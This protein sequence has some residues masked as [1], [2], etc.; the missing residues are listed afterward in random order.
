ISPSVWAWRHKRSNFMAK[1]LD[2]L[3]TIFPFEKPFFS[4]TTLDVRYI[5]HPLA[6]EIQN[7][8]NQDLKKEL[9][10]IFP[11][12]RKT[13]IERNFPL[14]LKAAKKLL[15]NNRNLKFAISISDKSLIDKIFKLENLDPSKFIFFSP[16]QNYL[17]MQKLKGAMATSGTINLELALNKVPTVVNFA[18]KAL[19]L[20][21]ARKI[22]KINLRFYCI[23]NIILQE[24]TFSELYGP[25]L[26]V[27]S[28]FESCQKLFFDEKNQI[29]C[30]KNCSKLKDILVS[31]NANKN[32]AKIILSFI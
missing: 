1:Y 16:D 26:N 11:G 10:G 4:H 13:E 30:K 23:V 31:K 8:K 17:F 32:A 22:L 19:D 24:E 28:L 20:F 2:L 14:Q 15:K 3:I 29:K 5:G 9:I 7:F 12:S 6:Y 25:N 27:D 21:I 18:I